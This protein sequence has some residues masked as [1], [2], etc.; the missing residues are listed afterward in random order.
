M[1][2]GI[3]GS[4]SAP[5]EVLLRSS[6]SIITQ[7]VLAAQTVGKEALSSLPSQVPACYLV[8]VSGTEQSIAIWRSAP[9][10]KST[11]GIVTWI[12]SKGIWRAFASLFIMS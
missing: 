6:W 1:T 8:L 7:A 10:T 12:S 11:P 9:N 3:G 4:I 2:S 5:P